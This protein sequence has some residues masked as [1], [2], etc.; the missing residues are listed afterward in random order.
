MKTKALLMICLGVVC[1]PIAQ[2]TYTDIPA[3]GSARFCGKEGQGDIVVQRINGDLFISM[4]G[5]N[6]RFTEVINDS[7]NILVKC[8]VPLRTGSLVIPAKAATEMASLQEGE[9]CGLPLILD[10]FKKSNSSGSGVQH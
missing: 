1:S 8:P 10:N 5:K 6:L 9:T 2:A 4:N 3:G 7:T